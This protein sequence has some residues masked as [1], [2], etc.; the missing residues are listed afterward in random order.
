MLQLHGKARKDQPAPTVVRTTASSAR[1]GFYCTGTTQHM[2]VVGMTFA[3]SPAHTADNVQAA[4]RCDAGGD[5]PSLTASATVIISDLKCAGYNSC[6]YAD[7]GSGF[8]IT[9]FLF[10]RITAWIG[11]S[12]ATSGVNEGVNC[13][14]TLECAGIHL[15][16]FGQDKADH[17][18]YALGNLTVNI[19][20]VYI[21]QTVNEAVKLIPVSGVASL[22][23][24]YHW[25][26]ANA[27]Y[28][29]NGGSINLSIDQDYILD[30]ADFSNTTI[31]TDGGSGS[32]NA[33]ILVQAID[34]AQIRNIDLHGLTA[35]SLQKS[36]VNIS[37]TST[38][39]IDFV[40]ATDWSI[41]DWSLATDDTYSAFAINRTGSA[42]F[43]TIIYSGNFDGATHGR[44][45][46]VPS[47]RNEFTFVQA[48][49]VVE[50]NTAVPEGHPVTARMSTSTA[51]IKLSGNLYCTMTTTNTSANTTETDLASYTLPAGALDSSVSGVS[52]TSG[53]HIR[54]W[55]FFANTAT[56]KTV[57]L[58]FD[59]T[60]IDS[61]SVT[62]SPQNVDWVIDT[63]L[64][65]QDSTNQKGMTRFDV[66]ATTQGVNAISATATL[67]NAIIIKV[68]GQN[69]TANA[70]DISLRGFCVDGLPN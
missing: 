1:H 17:G 32:S 35:R 43:G 40:N 39:K 50:A 37:G 28:Y 33:A 4:V 57:R 56:V 42:E 51:T 60:T 61:N 23:D 16:I 21:E 67:S 15:T 36:V 18:L 69:G 59:G 41:Y 12:G 24:P 3:A 64:H 22:T 45:V 66:G 30:K 10:D 65:R 38:G 68:T 46:W 26:V 9:Q 58:K 70:S 52:N 19:H 44:S 29:D 55:G 49:A 34:T 48:L 31:I 7:G 62:A 20:Q 63:Y 2:R 27:T 54:A 8:K 53:V 5:A 13:L 11:G 47:G 14:R 25:T 6:A